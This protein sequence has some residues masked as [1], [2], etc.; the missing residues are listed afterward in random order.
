MKGFKPVILVLLPALL[1]GVFM[2]AGY[3]KGNPLVIKLLG[4]SD[5]EVA[6]R[7]NADDEDFVDTP[8]NDQGDKNYLPP[9]TKYSYLSDEEAYMVNN[10]SLESED[11][12]LARFFP[13][14]LL[15]KDS[16]P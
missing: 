10:P 8:L 6:L 13:E 3:L 5:V 2:V 11:T 9:L 14:L 15:K 12:T 16:L 7:Q 1:G 4:G